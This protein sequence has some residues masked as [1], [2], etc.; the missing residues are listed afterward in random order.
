M[1]LIFLKQQKKKE[2]RIQ[3]QRRNRLLITIALFALLFFI[4]AMSL[5]GLGIS[6]YMYVNNVY[7]WDSKMIKFG[8]VSY[9]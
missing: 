3:S 8:L 9:D 6:I 1:N 7:N 4:L 2:Q 5:A